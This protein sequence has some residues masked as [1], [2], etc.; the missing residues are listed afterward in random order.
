MSFLIE[1]FNYNPATIHGTDSY[2]FL[3]KPSMNMV[4]CFWRCK[5]RD[6]RR[7]GR[8]LSN[9]FGPI[10]NVDLGPLNNGH[11][12]ATITAND[13]IFVERIIVNK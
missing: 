7:D 12:V 2:R 11:Y 3:S 13:D 10:S 8:L 6:K 9:S 1:K 5:I 4:L